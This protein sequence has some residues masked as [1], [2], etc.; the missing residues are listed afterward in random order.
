V[1]PVGDAAET[2]PPPQ[3][4][5]PGLGGYVADIVVLLTDG[6]NTRGI[7]PLDVLPYAVERR[8]RVYPIGFGTTNPAGRA[9]TRKQLGGDA[10]D[11]FGAGGFGGGGFGGGFRQFAVADEPTLQAI[12]ER[13]GASYHAAKDADQLQKVFSDLPNE[14]ATQR[15]RS[16]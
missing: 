6:R 2:E 10:F 4:G 1:Q 16:G 7:E 9:C 8:V 13:T 11:R 12:A 5:R 15:E 14:V 3:A